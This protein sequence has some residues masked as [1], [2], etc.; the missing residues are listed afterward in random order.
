MT[1]PVGHVPD[2][3]IRNEFKGTSLE[4]L[5]HGFPAGIQSLDQSLL[6]TPLDRSGRQGWLEFQ[7]TGLAGKDAGTAKITLTL[8]DSLN[9]RQ[10]IRA[11]AR[12]ENRKL[13]L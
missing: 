1:V 11:N 10:K 3:R 5:S 9:R 12:W 13:Y 7:A 6:E 8:V 4:G 2:K